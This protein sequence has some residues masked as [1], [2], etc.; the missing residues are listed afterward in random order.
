MY[1]VKLNYNDVR[2]FTMESVKKTNVPSGL[3]PGRT[4]T[5]TIKNE[6]ASYQ[7]LKNLSWTYIC[8]YTQTRINIYIYI[9]I[10]VYTNMYVHCT[11]THAYT[12]IHTGYTCIHPACIFAHRW[13]ETVSSFLSSKIGNYFSNF[14]FKRFVPSN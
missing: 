9:Y 3:H 1:N 4:I 12:N 14:Y 8:I 11:N 10:H 13:W 5:C 7:N 6:E 2:M